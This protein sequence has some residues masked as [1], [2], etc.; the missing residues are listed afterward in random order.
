MKGRRALLR[1]GTLS[2][3]RCLPGDQEK[4]ARRVYHPRRGRPQGRETRRAPFS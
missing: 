2:G 1:L 3:A 4:G